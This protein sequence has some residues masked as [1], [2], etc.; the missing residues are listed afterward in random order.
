MRKPF[1]SI[2]ALV[3]WCASASAQAPTTDLSSEVLQSC[4]LGTPTATWTALKLTPDQLRRVQ[5][6]QE[7][8]KEECDVAGVKKKA[9]SISSADGNTILSE[10]DN[11][12]SEDQY[13][14]WVAYCAGSPV[15]GQVPK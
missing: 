13:R 12:L 10:L 8:C 4:L 7:A 11:I 14:A 15:G 2:T 3:L 1:V 5:F 9:N 6:V